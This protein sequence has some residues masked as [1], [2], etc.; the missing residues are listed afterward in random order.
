MGSVPGQIDPPADVGQHVAHAGGER[1]LR[2]SGTGRP[3]ARAD[4]VETIN[5][6]NIFTADSIFAD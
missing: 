3:A 6:V 4:Q 2:R 1:A 5:N